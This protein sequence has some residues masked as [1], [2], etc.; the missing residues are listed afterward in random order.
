MII[1]VSMGYQGCCDEWNSVL[2]LPLKTESDTFQGKTRVF[3]LAPFNGSKCP[4]CTLLW[5]VSIEFLQL[6]GQRVVS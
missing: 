3:R 2:R 4:N 5:P 1:G 6:F